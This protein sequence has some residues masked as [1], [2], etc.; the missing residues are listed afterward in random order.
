MISLST[1]AQTGNTEEAQVRSKH[2]NKWEDRGP[3]SESK[4]SILVNK[5][6]SHF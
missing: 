1:A 2:L 4:G 6:G 5:V 3:K